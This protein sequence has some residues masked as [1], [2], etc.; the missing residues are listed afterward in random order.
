MSNLTV[1]YSAKDVEGNRYEYLLV[2]RDTCIL[3]AVHI[4][5]YDPKPKKRIVGK[6]QQQQ[7]ALA[8]V[9]I[10][11]RILLANPSPSR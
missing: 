4:G 6:T 10:T 9:L 5:V 11:V 7:T 2:P 1:S 8:D 3:A